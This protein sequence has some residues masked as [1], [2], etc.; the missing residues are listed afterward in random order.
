[1]LP[2]STSDPQQTVS[3]LSTDPYPPLLRSARFWIPA[4]ICMFAIMFVTVAIPAAYMVGSHRGQW[5]LYESRA[6]HQR[7]RIEAFFA[8][9]PDSYSSLSLELHSDGSTGLYGSVW[10]SDD[11]ELLDRRLNEMF[12]DE[13]AESLIA[14]VNGG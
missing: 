8:E 5:E 11:Y 12:G 9:H 14:N 13:L 4:S 6:D 7:G 2:Q 3:K 10:T 1:M